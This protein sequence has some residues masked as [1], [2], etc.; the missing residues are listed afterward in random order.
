MF[1]IGISEIICT[2]RYEDVNGLSIKYD[3]EAAEKPTTCPYFHSDVIHNEPRLHIHSSQQNLIRDTRSEGKLV[4]I[5][6]KIK[7]YRCSECGRIVS[8]RFTFYDKHSH[9]TYRLRE[10]FVRRCINGETF[11]YIARDYGVDHKTVSAAFRAYTDS[12]KEILSYAY[13]PEV[14][15]I[16]E[17]H[18]DDHYRLVLT[19]V[20]EQKLLDIKKDNSQ[21]TVRAYL[22]TLDKSVCKCATMDFAPA[23]A[24]AISSVLPEAIIV[25]DKF[26]VVQEINRCLDNVRK[27]LQNKSRKQGID[28]R[29]FKK[30]RTL[31]MTNWEDL[32]EKSV[33]ALDSWFR[34]FP[35]LYEAYLCKETFRDIYLTAEDHEEASRMFD[36]WIDAVPDYERFY[37]MKKTMTSRKQHILNYWYYKWTNAYTES[38]NNLIKGIAKAG[39]G[40][41]FETLR[42]RCLLGINRQKPERFDPKTAEY[43]PS[44]KISK[45][46]DNMSRKKE[47]YRVIGDAPNEPNDIPL[48]ECVIVYLEMESSVE[49]REKEFYDRIMAFHERL[50]TQIRRRSI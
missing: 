9:M 2:K 28:I 48:R 39:R 11:S 35:E 29:R 10:E 38:V 46:T 22:Q 21:K 26:H 23:Y 17:A 36:L 24:K 49:L 27:D 25:I 12:H 30:S 5:N 3:A 4:F 1:D 20:K 16:D 45:E 31:F 7:R 40:Y 14:L 15:G 47:L 18:I 34:E 37:P 32:N 44:D 19:D 43:K 8:D 13:T 6:L 41:K 42:E 33:E 50:S